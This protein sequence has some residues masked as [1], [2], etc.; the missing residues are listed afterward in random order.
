MNISALG[1]AQNSA[2]YYTELCSLVLSAW[3]IYKRIYKYLEFD[4]VDKN[5]ESAHEIDK[6]LKNI[7]LLSLRDVVPNSE[8]LNSF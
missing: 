6:F 2:E 1:Q 8:Q 4:D 7:M 3:I 5:M